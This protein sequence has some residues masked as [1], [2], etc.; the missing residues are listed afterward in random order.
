MFKWFMMENMLKLFCSQ[1]DKLHI[2]AV[3]I[4]FLCI[5]SFTKSY[6][7]KE[8]KSCEK[9]ALYRGMSALFKVIFQKC[10]RTISN[11]HYSS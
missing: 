5:I 9:T 4:I 7:L 6:F 1:I 2:T 8:K 10:F 3:K 11:Q